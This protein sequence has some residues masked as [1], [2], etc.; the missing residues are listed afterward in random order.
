VTKGELLRQRVEN[1]PE[2]PEPFDKVVRFKSFRD[3]ER[4]LRDAGIDPPRID[5]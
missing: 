3:R 2:D 5:S 4:A 1:A